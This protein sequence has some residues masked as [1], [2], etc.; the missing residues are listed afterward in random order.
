MIA[1][2][3]TRAPEDLAG[4]TGV[5]APGGPVVIRGPSPKLPW[6]DGVRYFG[7][8]PEAPGIFVPTVRRP[9][10]PLPLLAQALRRQIPAGPFVWL[11]EGRVVPL[12][13]ARPLAPSALEAWR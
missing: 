8:S 13:D 6:T 4:L 10:L 2:L 12:V 7:E 5:A 11:P 9:N 3:R 1:R